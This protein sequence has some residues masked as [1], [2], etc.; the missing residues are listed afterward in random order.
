MIPVALKVLHPRANLAAVRELVPLLRRY[1]ELTWEMTCRDILDR[2]TGQVLGSL[3]AIGNPLLLMATYVLVF[4]FLF[5]GRIGADGSPT[6]YTVYLLAGL[7]PWIAFQEALG[8][9]PT[10]I[11]G[12]ASLV[13]QIVFPS[14]ILPLKIAL[15]ALPTLLVGLAVTMA[16][17]VA[18]GAARPVGWLLLPVVVA[19][20]VLMTAG[21]SYVVAGIGVFVRD[22]KDVIAV[23]LSVGFFLHPILYAPGAAPRALE[24]AFHASPVTYLIWCYRDALFYG[25]I[26]HP[27]AWMITPLFSAALFTVGYRVFRMLRPTFGNVL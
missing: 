16:F 2:Y 12:N 7:V 18:I 11:T 17:S 22:I 15:G 26:A 14:E 21:I 25:E 5:R 23:L 9:A 1:R 13:K 3:W 6:E 4:T 27:W 8:R 10:A 20:H 19:C 24:L